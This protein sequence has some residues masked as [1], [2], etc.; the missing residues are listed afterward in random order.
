MIASVGSL[1]A[2]ASVNIGTMRCARQGAGKHAIMV[3]E[4]DALPDDAII[5]AL[6]AM[7]N[8]KSVTLLKKLV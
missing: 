5:A 4:L 6:R 3:L 2:G 1:L 8:I 7:T